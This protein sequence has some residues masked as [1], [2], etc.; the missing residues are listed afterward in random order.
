MK[1]IFKGKGSGIGAQGLVFTS[2]PSPFSIPD[3]MEK[4]NPK[5]RF[6]V[7][8]KA[9]TSAPLHNIISLLWRG[10]AGSR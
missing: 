8:S 1:Q 7:I 10:V 3:V 9:S 5:R 6:L 4:G 2:S